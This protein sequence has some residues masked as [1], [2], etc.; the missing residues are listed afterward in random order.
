MTGVCVHFP[1]VGGFKRCVVSLTLGDQCFPSCIEPP[2][3]KDIVE[4][5]ILSSIFVVMIVCK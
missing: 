5:I 2:Q 3:S 4:L 1:V